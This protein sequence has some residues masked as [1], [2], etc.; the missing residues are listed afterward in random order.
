M[1]DFKVTNVRRFAGIT[2]PPAPSDMR[3]S[4]SQVGYHPNM[5]KQF[6]S[7]VDFT[8]FEVVRTG[9]N[10]VVWTGGPSQR[11]V[12]SSDVLSSIPMYI[13]DFSDFRQEGRYIIRAGGRESFPFRI[14]TGLYAGPLRDAMR[15][16]YYQRA[17]TSVEMPY[18]EGPWVHPTSAHLAPPGTRKGWHD[19]GDLTIYM[20]TMTQAIWWLLESWEDFRPMRDD[21]NIPESGNNIPDLLD[22]TRWGLEWVLSVQSPE[23]GFH[24]MSAA[25][26]GNHYGTP[27]GSTFPHTVDPF[28]NCGGQTVQQAGKAVA[29]LAYASK[30]YREWDAAFADQC[31]AA[32]RRGWAWMKAN[33]NA[34]NDQT[35][36][37]QGY[38]QG[39]DPDLLQTQ[40]MWAAA[41]M[42]YATGEAEF[43]AAFQANYVVPNWISSYSKSDA[44]AGK[45][46]L[47]VSS[48]ADANKQREIRQAFRDH[49]GTVRSDANGH[50]FQFATYYYWGCNSNALHRVM[51]FSYQAYRNDTTRTADRDAVLDNLHYIFGR[52]FLNIAY[53]SGLDRWGATK[54]RKEGFHHWMKALNATPYHF[55]GALAGGP[56]QS[57]DAGDGDYWN[58]S[59]YPR[60]GGTPLDGRFTD[61]SSWSTNEITINW[62]G[63]YLYAMLAANEIDRRMSGEFPPPP[64]VDPPVGT[65]SVSPLSLPFGGGTVT[66]TWT[67]GNATTVTIDNIPVAL[68]GSDNVTVTAT[69]TFRLVV[70]NNVDSRSYSASVVVDTVQPPPPPPPA[71]SLRDTVVALMS[72]VGA[73][74]GRVALLEQQ[75]PPPP[76]QPT[77]IN[78]NT[79]SKEELMSLPGIGSVIAQ[80]IINY[81]AAHG[82]FTAIEDLMRVSGIGA[83]KFAAI[84]H[85]IT[86]S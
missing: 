11:T 29:V 54:W 41:A 77:L 1:D 23:G 63:A 4:A 35:C 73:L 81:R 47:R 84:R 2:A 19:A 86:V 51:Q 62:Q 36:G 13:G 66:R 15:F 79:A 76:P 69:K 74:E 65:I 80:N 50:P 43:D 10:V 60:H 61:N 59:R 14:G 70:S 75:G 83:V 64:P 21:L 82:P 78:I 39:T 44:F 42:L 17:F 18:A 71:S 37:G 57:P 58:D 45:M 6:S 72:R 38:P 56:N 3:I 25:H 34:I 26:G 46:Y 16:F 55:P 31:L 28:V 27:Y 33:P 5:K 53:V 52:N 48:G 68:S 7:P 67:S 12:T 20:P 30:V 9:D 49:A 85:L 40:W 24:Q 22:E 8:S 32:A